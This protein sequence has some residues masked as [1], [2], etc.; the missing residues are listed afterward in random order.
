MANLGGRRRQIGYLC[1]NFG[2]I[3]HNVPAGESRTC[4][5]LSGA[6]QLFIKVLS[7]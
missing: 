2:K 3:L 1:N 5:S 7:A 4:F 6:G